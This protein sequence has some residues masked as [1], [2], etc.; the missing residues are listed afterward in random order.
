MPFTFHY[1]VELGE[2]SED[3]EPRLRSLQVRAQL[4]VSGHLSTVLSQS[5]RDLSQGS[6]NENSTANARHIATTNFT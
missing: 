4:A 2:M 1:G 6:L 5:Q 3:L